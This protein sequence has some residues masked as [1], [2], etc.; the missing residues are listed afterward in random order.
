MS[1][2]MILGSAQSQTNSIKNLTT[3]QIGSYQQIQQALSNFMFQT[4]SLQGAAYDSAKAYCGS[5]LS[6]LIDG[7][8]LLK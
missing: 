4:N 5:V 7:C 8:I 6:P 2:N 1:I 3:S